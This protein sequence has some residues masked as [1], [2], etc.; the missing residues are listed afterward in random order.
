MSQSPSLLICEM[1]PV[2]PTT[3]FLGQNQTRPLCSNSSKLFRS[4]Q[5]LVQT[6]WALSHHRA[7]A[8]AIP[9][10]FMCFLLGWVNVCAFC[11]SQPESLPQGSP[12]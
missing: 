1:G 4:A 10:A 5:D 6:S 3:L 9:S 12:P 11:R 8:Y 7:F 2:M